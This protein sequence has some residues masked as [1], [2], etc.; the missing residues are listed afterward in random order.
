MDTPRELFLH[1]LSDTLSAE[2]I[3]LKLAPELRREAQHA[4]LKTALQEHEAET[5]GQIRRL[6]EVFK[7]L[8]EKPEETTCHAAEGLRQ[9]HEALHEESPAPDVLEIGNVL[10]M[11][12]S[13]HYEIASYTGLVQM[14]RDLGEREVADLLKQTLD[15]E[16]AMAKR[17]VTLSKDLGKEVKAEIKEQ[18]REAKQQE[19]AAAAK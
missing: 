11:A 9:E 6:E 10:G 3:F 5:K 2:H 16:Q 8:G 17:V 14:A 19:K 15:E 4:E 12:K 1:E 7:V 13:E 18:E